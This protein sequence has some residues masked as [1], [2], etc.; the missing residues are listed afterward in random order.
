MKIITIGDSHT[1]GYPGFDPLSKGDPHSTY[2]FWLQRALEKKFRRKIEIL[3]FGL[4]GDTSEGI[5]RRTGDILDNFDLTQVELFIV[6]GGGNSWYLNPINYSQTLSNLLN[7]CTLIR[8]RN[9]EIN[10]ILTSISPFGSEKIM[11][12]LKD[13]SYELKDLIK[14]VDDNGIYYFDWFTLLYDE[15]SK[16][17]IREYDSGDSEHLNINGYRLIGEAISDFIILNL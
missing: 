2:Q 3:N 15:K 5:L 4:P 13:I 12:Q 8:N 6:N 10:V 16:M 11:H 1:A 9:K 7:A 17:L 14:N